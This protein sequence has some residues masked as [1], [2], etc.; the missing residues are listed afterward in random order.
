MLKFLANL[1]AGSAST[2][3]TPPTVRL[4]LTPVE[5]RM[6]PAAVAPIGVTIQPIGGAAIVH[7]PDSAQFESP[8]A[9]N[10]HNYHMITGFFGQ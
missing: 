4:E 5:D 2:T 1:F 9:N 6:A 8:A 3:R 7:A 10:L